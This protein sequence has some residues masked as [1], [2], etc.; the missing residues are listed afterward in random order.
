[1]LAPPA[2]L[3]YVVIHELCHLTHMDH[4]PAFWKM[5]EGIDPDFK[6]HRKWLKDNAESLVLKK[7]NDKND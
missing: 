3:D 6:E 2:V 4:S 5:V 1:V 7:E